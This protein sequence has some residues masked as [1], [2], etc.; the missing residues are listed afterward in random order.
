MNA[1][2]RP[3]RGRSLARQSAASP[4]R[5]HPVSSGSRCVMCNAGC[6]IWEI[7]CTHVKPRA[8]FCSVK[9]T[10][11]KQNTNKPKKKKSWSPMMMCCFSHVARRWRQPVRLHDVCLHWGQCRRSRFAHYNRHTYSEA[12]VRWHH[13]VF[14]NVI[15]RTGFF[16]F[17]YFLFLSAY[18]KYC[19]YPS[20]I[21]HRN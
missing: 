17:I 19:S 8:T 20:E 7:W 11:Q 13:W 6:E 12:Q 1:T 14:L 18:A 2:K 16:L 5:H 10:N 3:E 21:I 4:R 9:K 15:N